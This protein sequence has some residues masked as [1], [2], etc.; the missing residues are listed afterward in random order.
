MKRTK[1]RLKINQILT[2][3]KTNLRV[4]GCLLFREWDKKDKRFYYWEEWEITGL[5]DYDSWVEYDHS[6]Q[7]VSLYEPIR[8][9]QAI[10]PT[11]LKKGQ[12]FTVS[13][14]DGKDHVVV[15]DEVGIGEIMN[16]KGKNTYQV[17]PKELMAYATLRDTGAPKNRQLITIEKYNNREYDAY[18]KVQLS[19]KEQKEMF[20]RTI[21]PID[22]TTIIVIAIFIAIILFAF[23]FDNNSD[24]SNGGGHG[25]SRSVYG[26]SSG[27][28]GK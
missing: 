27:G 11:Q 3:K 15:I 26:G 5:A 2:G 16:I 23:I 4:V 21:K 20:G 8:F 6:D 22:W 18:R 1:A 13:E 25:G 10:D 19:N 17:F 9:T 28:L 14:Q 12:S 24:S 7:T